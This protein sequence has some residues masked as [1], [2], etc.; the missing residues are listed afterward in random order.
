MKAIFCK[1]CKDLFSLSFTEKSCICNENKSS[2][3]YI[4][5]L[6]AIYS[7]ENAIPIGFLNNE[8]TYAI[9]NQ[10]EL[11]FSPDFKAFVISKNCETFKRQ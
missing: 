5:E 2:G 11:G 7:G 6:N 3:K 4:D 1:K 10:K 9:S 8:F